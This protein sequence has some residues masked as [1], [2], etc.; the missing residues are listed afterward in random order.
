MRIYIKYIPG[1]FSV[2]HSSVHI[3]FGGDVLDMYRY[4]RKGAI[5]AGLQASNIMPT[6]RNKIIGRLLR[7]AYVTLI[8]YDVPL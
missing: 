3:C 8:N 6:A 5:L 2:P 4:V 1:T 7:L